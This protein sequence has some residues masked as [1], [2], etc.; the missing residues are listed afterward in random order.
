MKKALENSIAKQNVQESPKVV[1]VNL[2]FNFF[3]IKLMP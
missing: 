3:L 1:E 2:I